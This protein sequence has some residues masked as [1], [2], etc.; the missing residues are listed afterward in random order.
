MLKSFVRAALAGVLMAAGV[1]VPAAG[2]PDTEFDIYTKETETSGITLNGREW[3]TSCSQYSPMVDRCRTEIVATQVKEVNG[4]FV[5]TTGWAFNNLTYTASLPEASWKGNPLAQNG[6]W[7]AA[8]GRKWRTECHTPTT[9]NGGCRSYIE[10]DVIASTP[11]GNRWVR[12]EIFNNQVRFL[13][14]GS[15]SP[16]AVKDVNLRECLRASVADSYPYP[17]RTWP[18]SASELARATEFQCNAE[19]RTWE[20]MPTLPNVTYMNLLRSTMHSFKGMPIFPKLQTLTLQRATVKSFAGF[21]AHPSLS[22]LD[23]QVATMETLAG[24]PTLPSLT[25]LEASGSTLRSAAMPT[26]PKLVKLMLPWTRVNSLTELP[27]L[28]SLEELAVSGSFTT[29]A[30]MPSFP[31]LTELGVA[32][33]KI[34]NAVPGQCELKSLTGLPE[35]PS[36]ERLHL[37]RCPL[38]SLN[39]LR[40]LPSLRQLTLRDSN[41]ATYGGAEYLLTATPKLKQLELMG[42]PA[43]DL[44]PLQP[45]RDAGILVITD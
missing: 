4:Q 12:K 22:I 43:T 45:L 1:A 44:A 5:A 16:L 21:P 23:L 7:T 13:P 25:L 37:S 36:L 11:T 41:I 8:D 39:G 10:A 3:R 9:G 40:P 20:G 24:L 14:S 6:S 34:P 33:E 32:G 31:R 27:S 17:S 19:V 18:I 29:F 28:P 42:N 30:G 15:I 35:L 26:Q 38:I 2:S